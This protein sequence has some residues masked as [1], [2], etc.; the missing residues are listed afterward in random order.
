MRQQPQHFDA[1]Q[2]ARNIS[3]NP[4][5]AILN[6]HNQH[7]GKEWAKTQ[8]KELIRLGMTNIKK[9]INLNKQDKRKWLHETNIN[10]LTSRIQ[11]HF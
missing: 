3:Q 4:S 5:K 2:K 11:I 6:N 8:N 7:F 10:Q 1:R 9:A